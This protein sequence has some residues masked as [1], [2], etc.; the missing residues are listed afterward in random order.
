MTLHPLAKYPGPWLAS[1]TEWTTTY[2]VSTGDRHLYHLA[3]HAKYGNIVRIG[4][5]TLSFNTIGALK[6]IYVNRKGNVQKSQHY[7]IFEASTGTYS[8]HG[9]VD[10]KVHAFRRRVLEHA[11]SNKAMLSAERFIVQNV[12]T[13]CDIIADHTQKASVG[14]KDGEASWSEPLNV[15]EW[16]TYLNYDIMGDLVF[17][18]RF[19][20]MTSN[21]HRFVP[22]LLINASAFVNSVGLTPSQST[23]ATLYMVLYPPSG[24]HQAA[25][26]LWPFSSLPTSPSASLFS[27]RS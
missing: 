17:G 16:S 14:G 9:E 27:T 18:K 11:F 13:L 19:N 24:G 22:N 4:P 12:K 25:N 3:E 10:K 6:E 26:A 5:N 20:C 8:T 21:E 7:K 23:L 1:I 2:K 15:S